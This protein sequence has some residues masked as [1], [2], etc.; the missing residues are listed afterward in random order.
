MGVSKQEGRNMKPSKV[1]FTDMRAKVG[2][3]LLI[4]MD[5]LIQKAGIK[6]IDFKRKYTAIKIHFGEPGNLSFLRPNFA[7]VLA[8][9]IKKLG[10]M[11]FLTDCNTLY[12]GGRNNALL[13][14]DAAAENGYSVLSTGCQNIIADGL[15]GTDDVDVPVKDGVYVDKA[16]IGRAIM[17]AD[18]VISLNHFKGHECTGF[19]GA[20]KNLGMGSGSRAG[21]MIMHNDGKPTVDDKLC[22]GC[23]FCKKFCNENAITVKAAK[24]GIDH[25]KCAGCGRCIGVCNFH[26][27]FNENGSSFPALSCKIAE[28]AKAVVDG[29][30]NFHVSV[31]NQVSPN[32]DCHNENDAAVVPD[33]GIFAGFDPVALDQ[34]CIDAVNAAQGIA[35]S[36][37]SE[38]KKIPEYEKGGM[39]HFTGIHPSTDWRVQLSHAEKIGIGTTKYELVTV[40]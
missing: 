30:P 35:C 22:V 34:A 24:A 17:D 40:K 14:L 21:K 19:G 11:P 5:R 20:L 31:V 15:K 23:G 18:V 36:I 32:C 9:R 27:I 39:D 29:R 12:V 28:Y 33:I 8:D 16:R 2:E 13:H 1:Y 26:A 37:L 38:R 3:S 6:D 25:K 4:K 7:K 10:G